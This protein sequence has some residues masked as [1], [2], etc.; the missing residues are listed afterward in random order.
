VAV[1]LGEG[2]TIEAAEARP[3]EAVGPDGDD[4][5]LHDAVLRAG[6]GC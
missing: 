6:R 4:I 3:C 1:T 2:W 5:T